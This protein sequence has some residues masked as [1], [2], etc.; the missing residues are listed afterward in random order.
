VETFELKQSIGVDVSKDDFKVCFSI[1]DSQM[2][3]V[4][5]GSHAFKNTE[6]GFHAFQE[7]A[8]SE[9]PTEGSLH[10]TPEATGVYYEGLAYYLY[11]RRYPV[12]VVLPN[13]SES[14]G[15][16]SGVKSET[17]KTDARILSQM[18]L[19]RNLRLWEPFSPNLRILKQLT[20][21]RDRPVRE[22]TTASD[23]KHAYGHQGKPYRDSINRCSAHISFSDE[24]TEQIEKQIFEIVK[25]DKLLSD[26]LAYLRSIPGAGLLTAVIIVSETNGF[27]AVT[28]IKQLNSYAGTDVKIMESG[29]WKGQSKIGKRGNSHIRKALY[30]PTIHG[31]THDDAVIDFYQRLKAKKGI[32]MVANVAAQRKLLGL[33]YT[34]WKKEENYFS[35]KK[36]E[37]EVAKK[38][39]E[40]AKKAA[41]EEAKEAAKEEAKVAKEAAKEEAKAAKTAAKEEAKAAKKGSEKSN[42]NGLKNC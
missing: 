21:E 16:G 3:I 25:G 18:G 36:E 7:W 24:Q 26:G 4:T 29:K 11:E 23:H 5:K 39:A 42:G 2:R 8:Q 9:R 27:A 22:R 19:E 10:V 6:K 40:A 33:I 20:R 30:M 38:E 1:Y 17:D 35:D 15:K 41:K 12:H 28:G 37:K 14:Y 34:L 31:I 13:Q 32:G